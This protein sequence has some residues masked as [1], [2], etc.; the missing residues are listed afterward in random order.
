MMCCST[1]LGLARRLL[2]LSVSFAVVLSCY[3]F[4]IASPSKPATNS[5]GLSTPPA[6]SQDSELTLTSSS[7]TATRTGVLLRWST[8]SVADNLGFNIY[9]LKDGRR[10][11]ANKEIIPGILFAPGT[12]ALMRAGYSFAWFD[13]AGSADATYF[14]ESVN[15]SGATKLHNAIV[16]VSSKAV[17]E[18]DQAPDALSTGANESTDTFEKRY[19]AEQVQQTNLTANAI[20]T[21]WEIASQTALKIAISKEGWYRVTQPQMVAA[22]FNP[23]VDIRNLRLFVN[24]NEVAINT[25][26]LTGQFR[27][28]DYIEFYGH[29]VDTPTTDK[30][31][32]Y[33]IAGTTP[34]KRVI[35][36]IQLDGDPPPPPPGPSPTP[37]T[38]LPVNPT[39]PAS[40]R[41]VLS[42]PIFYSWAQN[43]LSYL[44]GSLEPRNAPDQR[45]AKEPAASNPSVV[46]LDAGNARPDYSTEYAKPGDGGPVASDSPAA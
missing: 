27:S 4:T 43:D 39:A 40:G 20:E 33:L 28:S 37:V 3:A 17:S 5:A 44:M 9:R 38:D 41:P 26:Q 36:G 14:I 1:R 19:P 34:G 10:T 13:R 2:A 45:E 24:A 21:Q 12:P 22:G 6:D 23:V 18:F 16:P 11:Q 42:D 46:S 15:V 31:I 30:Q 32:Y 29:G 35:G 7:A 25:S 8:N